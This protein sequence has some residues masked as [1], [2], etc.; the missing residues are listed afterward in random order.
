M[1][2]AKMDPRVIWTQTPASP[3]K[4]QIKKQKNKKKTKNPQKTG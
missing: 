2:R 3:Q 4:Q 1:R